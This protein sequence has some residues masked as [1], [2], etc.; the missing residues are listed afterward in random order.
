VDETTYDGAEIS[1]NG[2]PTIQLK[3]EIALH[4]ASGIMIWNLEYDS[5][6]QNT[7]LLNAIY[8]KVK[9]AE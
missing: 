1:Y 8:K 6:D 7:S 2:I 4:R 5:M 9:Q 3:T